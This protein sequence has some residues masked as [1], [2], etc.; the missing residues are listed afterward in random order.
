MASI[1]LSF[2]IKDNDSSSPGARR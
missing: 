1:G 2:A